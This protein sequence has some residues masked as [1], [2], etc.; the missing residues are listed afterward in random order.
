LSSAA[1]ADTIRGSSRRS[2]NADE[3]SVSK[4]GRTTARKSAGGNAG[5]LR[6]TSAGVRSGEKLTSSTLV[7][8][9]RVTSISTSG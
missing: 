2:R 9:R 1:G 7:I 5:M 3:Y 6:N 8:C 4:F